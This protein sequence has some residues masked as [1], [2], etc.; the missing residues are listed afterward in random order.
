VERK[1]ERCAWFRMER[2]FNKR[3]D[4]RI[5]VNTGTRPC[6]HCC[7]G[8]AISII[9][10]E[11]LFVAFCTQHAMRLRHFVIYGPSRS[12]IFSPYYI[13]KDMVLG[14]KKL[15]GHKVCV[16]IYSVTF[17]WKKNYATS[18]WARYDQKCT[19][20]FMWSASYSCQI[21]IKLEFSRKYFR[22]TLTYT[23]FTE[24][25]LLLPRSYHS[26]FS[27]TSFSSCSRLFPRLLVSYILQSTTFFF[28]LWSIQ[29]AQEW[30]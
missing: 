17:D 15:N 27:L 10:S 6:N 19:L 21:L 11:C 24:Y 18:N 8:K 23:N 7:C 4:V 3:G 2:S 30:T 14:G 1:Q 22:E 26:T 5:N 29:S 12:T 28:K 16:F 25:D 13:I 20:V 9:Y